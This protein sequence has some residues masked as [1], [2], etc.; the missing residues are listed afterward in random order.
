MPG[1]SRGASREGELYQVGGDASETLVTGVSKRLELGFLRQS[2][3]SLDVDL[4]RRTRRFS[5]DQAQVSDEL[6]E[7]LKALG[8]V[9]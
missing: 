7:K 8:Y 4:R 6:R 9:D 3:R 2:L 5:P 1:A